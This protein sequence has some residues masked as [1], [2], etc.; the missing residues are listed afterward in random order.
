[1]LNICFSSLRP[2]NF[3]NTNTS[4]EP[5]LFQWASQNLSVMIP[6]QDP[7]TTIIHLQFSRGHLKRSFNEI[8]ELSADIQH[9]DVRYLALQKKH[10]NEYR[11]S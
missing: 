7:A 6:T 11:I 9:T 1:M 2:H 10:I 4:H 5:A 3:M 8:L